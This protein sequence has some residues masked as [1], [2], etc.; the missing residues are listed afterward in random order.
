MSRRINLLPLV[1]QIFDNTNA[2][3]TGYKFLKKHMDLINTQY[4]I[5]TI[6]LLT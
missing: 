4:G 6:P 5:P 3:Y 2:L 1:S